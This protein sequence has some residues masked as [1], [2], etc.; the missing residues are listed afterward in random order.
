[1]LSSGFPPNVLRYSNE[2]LS[3]CR[4][5]VGE[6]GEEAEAKETEGHGQVTPLVCGNDMTVRH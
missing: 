1:M 5:A 2:A 6:D 4:H 3:R